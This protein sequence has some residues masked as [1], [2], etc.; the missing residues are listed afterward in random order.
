MNSV[1]D[2]PVFDTLKYLDVTAALN[3]SRD[4]K[5]S[6]ILHLAHN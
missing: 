3:K 2:V 4:F 6:S 1:L 5:V